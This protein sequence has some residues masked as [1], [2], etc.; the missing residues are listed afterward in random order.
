LHEAFQAEVEALT[1][2]C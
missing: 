1:H 2:V